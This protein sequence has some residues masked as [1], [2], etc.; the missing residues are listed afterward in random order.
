VWNG[1]ALAR[2]VAEEPV[3]ECNIAIMGQWRSLNSGG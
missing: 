2:M 3:L 1:T